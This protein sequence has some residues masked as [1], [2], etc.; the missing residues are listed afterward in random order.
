MRTVGKTIDME[1]VAGKT[2]LGT[3]AHQTKSLSAIFFAITID[4]IYRALH[5]F[6]NLSIH[7]L[8]GGWLSYILN[9]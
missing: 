9:K 5:I 1:Q 3:I 7:P 6:V 8:I 2:S 4:V